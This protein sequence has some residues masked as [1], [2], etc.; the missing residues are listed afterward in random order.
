MLSRKLTFLFFVFFIQLFSSENNEEKIRNVFAEKWAGASIAIK[1]IN[2]GLTN[3]NYLIT[4]ET[5][6]Y[7]LRYSSVD[8]HLLG[9]SL[10]KEYQVASIM[11]AAG[12]APKVILH[13]PQERMM[14]SEYVSMKQ[15]KVDLRDPCKMGQFCQVVRALHALRVDLPSVFCPFKCIQ[16]YARHALDAGA[17]LPHVFFERIFPEIEKIRS[18]LP[19]TVK[20]P[21]HLDLYSRNV[22]D[23]GNHLYLVDWEYAAMGDPLFDLATI[24]SADFFSDEE[25]NQLLEAYLE[26]VPSEKELNQFY[27]MRILADVR[28]SLWGYLQERI[29]PLEASFSDIG[30]SFLKQALMRLETYLK[31]DMDVEPAENPRSF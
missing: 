24:P 25:M 10:E 8:N 29:S 18:L 11:A 13:I 22:L 17:S 31:A 26:K 30:E 4:R 14:L 12:L 28:W 15:D 9:V 27:M 7:F 21:C 23:D 1:K 19:A 20:V 5:I 16:D 3:E 6:P 2:G